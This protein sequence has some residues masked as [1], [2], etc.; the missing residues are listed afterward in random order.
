M[1]PF[2]ATYAEI[3][4]S[5]LR[6][7][8]RVLRAQA[9]REIWFCPMVKANAYG[10]G[11]LAVAKVLQEMKVDAIGVALVEEGVTLR[12][13]GIQ[14]PI[15]IFGVFSEA[16][17]DA[18][19][20]HQLTPVINRWLDLE[21]FAKR[22][23]EPLSVHLKFNTGMNRLGFDLHD[24]AKVKDYFLAN[25]R[26]RLEGICS[27]L[28]QGE[29][30][31]REDGVSG[32]QARVLQQVIPLFHPRPLVHLFNSAA[33]MTGTGAR[34]W[35]VR[36]GI[37]LYGAGFPENTKLKP[38]MHLRS[39]IAM[40][41]EVAA[42]EGVSYHSKWKAQQSSMIAT[43][44]IGY[45]DGFLRILTNRADALV[46]SQRV[47]LVGTV[48]MDYIMLD[49]SSVV[50][51]FGPIQAGEPVT[52]WGKQGPSW[53]RADEV[54]EKAETISYE[55]LTNVGPRVPRRYWD[56]DERGT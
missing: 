2:R 52:L 18:A 29:D 32:H 9:G 50:A 15:L 44:P 27:H 30:W 33:L 5:A 6:H 12:Q 10:H 14:L 55:V 42:G 41:H 49:V 13:G 37:A 11:S 21:A 51:R 1:N 31:S 25:P 48:C 20:K 35:G 23:Q 40:L 43:V 4:L 22:A 53:I 24:G 19:I 8:V 39:E 28:V 16:G 3:D 34:G 26:L 54:A 56:G 46:R 47:P 7:N 38:V 17:A 36:P 45:G